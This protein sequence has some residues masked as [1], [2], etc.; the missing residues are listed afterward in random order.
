MGL[1]EQGGAGSGDGEGQSLSLGGHI[2]FGPSVVETLSYTDDTA[3]SR[4]V[5]Q[6]LLAKREFDEVDMAKR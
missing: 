1:G 4:S 3:M 6:S 2:T 5:V